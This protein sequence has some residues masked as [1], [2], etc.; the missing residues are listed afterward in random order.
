MN[1]AAALVLLLLVSTAAFCEDIKLLSFADDLFNSGDYYRSITEYKRYIFYNPGGSGINHSKYRAALSYLMAGRFD[2]A[3][4]AF[5]DIADKSPGELKESAMLAC[6]FS[7]SQKGDYKYSNMLA[8]R[9]ILNGRNPLIADKA[10]YLEGF[11]YLKQGEFSG[12]AG[13]FEL[14][15]ND[16]AILNSAKQLEDYLKKSGG[17]EQRSPVISSLLSAVVPGAG[18][19]YCGNFADA[20]IS[21]AI[22][23]FFI[24]NT[25]AAF[26]NNSTT[27]KYTYGI[28][29]AI[30]YLSNIYGSA[31]AANRFNDARSAEY[32]DTATKLRINIINSDF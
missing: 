2:E 28:P 17:I 7:Y 27:D 16:Q 13:A 29:A 31:A 15:K 6:A 30:F 3:A 4:G 18:Y 1:K 23:G 21:F 12:A 11:N 25:A 24:Y 20:I 9:L 5:E 19:I 8:G 32:M 22:N 14:V 10:A 26:K